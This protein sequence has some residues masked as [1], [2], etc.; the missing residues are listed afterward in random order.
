MLDRVA[1]ARIDLRTTYRIGPLLQLWIDAPQQP[2]IEPC[3][4]MFAGE[5]DWEEARDYTLDTIRNC[6]D[7]LLEGDLDGALDLLESVPLKCHLLGRERDPVSWAPGVYL[8]SLR[9]LAQ[10]E[11]PSLVLEDL[12]SVEGDLSRPAPYLEQLR[13]RLAEHLKEGEFAAR[14]GGGG[15]V[16]SPFPEWSRSDAFLLLGDEVEAEGFL[17]WGG[18]RVKSIPPQV[19]GL[20]FHLRGKYK[21]LSAADAA[22]LRLIKPGDVSGRKQAFKALVQRARSVLY[23]LGAERKPTPL[24]MCGQECRSRVEIVHKRTI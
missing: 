9:R 21:V 6:E 11:L 12:R 23:A 4:D 20:L 15:T 16:P 14:K 5:P 10:G 17:A 8:H 19:F 7:W 1:D 22:K 18:N 3:P 2:T 24:T 13:R